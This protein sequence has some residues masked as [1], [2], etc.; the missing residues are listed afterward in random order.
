MPSLL[1]P[2][3]HLPLLPDRAAVS[4]R[5]PR[6]WLDRKGRLSPLRGVTFALLLTPGL[7]YA[8]RYVLNGLG[9][10]P[11]HEALLAAGTWTI[12]WLLAS[13]AVTP[14]KAVLGLPGLVVVRRMIGLGALAY[15][16]VHLT[17]FAA[18]ENWRLLHVASE[19][20][21]RF[22]LL[23]G[24]AALAGL[25][26]LGWTS[27][28]SWVKRLGPAWKRLHRLAYPLTALG[29]FHY[30]LQSKADV[31]A[32]VLASGLFAWLMLWRLLPAG[33]DRDIGGLAPLAMMAGLATAAVEF[34]WYG[35]ATRVDPWR[36]LRGELDVSFGFRPAAEVLALG[37][38]VAVAVGLRRLS[39]TRHGSGLCGGVLL[40]AAAG[41]TGLLAAYALG[42]SDVLDFDSAANVAVAACCVGLP[43]LVSAW[44]WR[45]RTAADGRW[46]PALQNK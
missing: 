34:A 24:V 12:W 27:R 37:A 36:V 6:P 7:Y 2:F 16:V 31:S 29:V 39:L 46:L 25:G 43:A 21:S 28:D 30:Y 15:G 1:T 14:V 5:L 45:V 26:V 17:L 22:Y 38:L 11:I 33:R 8:G 4:V 44:R 19:I 32:A 20:V 3:Q 23:V 18:D 41:G 10:R 13:L 40:H 42:W 9:P 35:I